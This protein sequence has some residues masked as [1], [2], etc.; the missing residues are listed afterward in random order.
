M[1]ILYLKYEH[2]NH[3]FQQ[4]KNFLYK[5]HTWYTSQ[6]LIIKSFQ[7]VLFNINLP[8]YY[9]IIESFIHKG[10]SIKVYWIHLIYPWSDKCFC[11]TLKV[12]N[13]LNT[14]D[15]TMKFWHNVLKYEFIFGMSPISSFA[16]I[17]WNKLLLKIFKLWKMN[18]WTSKV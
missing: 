4:M 10:H 18:Y 8:Q 15:L 12:P 9:I 11:T 2:L 6:N 14:K 17:N 13:K 7:I 3:Y 5:L 16:H 1:I